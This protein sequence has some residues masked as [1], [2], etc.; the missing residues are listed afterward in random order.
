MAKR[1]DKENTEQHLK[2]MRDR[3]DLA[4]SNESDERK[5]GTEDLK[6][7]NGDQWEAN[8]IADRKGRLNLTINKMPTYL[9]QIDGDIRLHKPGIKIKAV[10]SVSDPQTADVIEGLIRSIERNSA[11]SR[12]YAYAGLHLAAAGRGAW[13]VLTDYISDKSFDQVVKIERVENAYAVYYDPSARQEDKQDGQFMFLIQEMSEEAYKDQYGNDPVDFSVDGD[14][15]ANW[16]TEGKIRVAEYFYKKKVSDRTLYLL[17]DGRTVFELE[18]GDEIKDRR[19]VPSYEI[20]WEK[21][22]G[23]RILEGPQKVAGTMYPIVLVWGKQLFV[24]GKLDVRGIARHAKDSQRLYNYFSSND[25]ETTALQPKQPYLM[26]DSCLGAYKTVWDKASDEN[27]PYL[28]YK[29]DPNNVSLK[30]FREAPAMPSGGNSVQLQRAD[31]DMRDT[32]G[33][34]K[35]AMGMQSNEKSGIAIKERKMES[36][37]GQYAFM[38]NLSAGVRTTGKI[39][40]GM[41]PEIYDTARMLRILGPDFKEKV[42]KINQQGGIDLTT[43]MYDV[44]IDV[45]PSQSTQREEFVEK[46]SAILPNIPPEQAA[47]ITDILFESMD[48]YRADDIAVRLKKMIPPE[49]LGDTEKPEGDE[50]PNGGSQPPPAGGQPPAPPPP[51]PMVQKQME[52]ASVQ[53]EIDM[54]TAQVK[55]EQEQ[56]KLEGLKLDNEAKK[57]Q[58]KE[59]IK[60]IIEELL[61][62]EQ[63]EKPDNV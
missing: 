1:K 42:I 14:E 35:A 8:V 46:I 11:A 52:A 45:G 30:P 34:Q 40:L 17:E 50:A 48:F 28:P 15:L 63:G 12:I 39:I 21:V 57:L 47:M 3:L 13:R 19:Q 9:D 31:Q 18:E 22:D 56:A 62:E 26:P 55:L 36:D 24:D 23:K 61:N 20:W 43:G 53:M 59:N 37:T 10:D 32:I 6:F 27:Y 33:L 16:Q 58:S 5:K 49:I 2:Q 41:I 38:D 4:V 25:A 44:D 29:V 51:D 54:R 7:I 60:V